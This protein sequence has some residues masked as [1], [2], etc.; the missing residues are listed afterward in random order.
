MAMRTLILLIALLLL[1]MQTQ[2]EPL[3]GRAEEA[4]DQE[5]LGDDDQNIAISLGGEESTAFLDADVRSEVT[6]Y[7]RRG[8]CRFPERL[9]GACRYRNIVYRLCCR[10]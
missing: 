2:A 1:A 8:G 7:C 4:L 6:C 10:R 9:V 5:Q 3:L